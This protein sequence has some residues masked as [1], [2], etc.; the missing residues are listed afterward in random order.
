MATQKNQA[1]L[2]SDADTLAVSFEYVAY[3]GQLYAPVDYETGDGD[4]VP[5]IERKCWVPLST[6]DVR[7]KAR[8]QFNTMFKDENQLRGFT[9]MVAQSSIEVDSAPPWLLVKTSQGLRVMK[10]DGQ[11]HEPDGSF[12]P[13]MLMP[14]LNENADDKAE[15]MSVITG[16]LGGEEEEALSLLRHLA[17]T[18]APHWSAGKYVL[19]IG[20]GSNGKSV[21]MTMLLDLFGVHN[22][23]GV[24]RQV[25]S[26]GS[27]GVFDLNGKL[28]NLVF[29]GPAEFVKDS[30]KEKSV[31]TG[32][33]IKIRRL[34]SSEMSTIKTNALFV[35]GL[36]QEPRSRDKSSAL[37][38]RLVRFWFPN[39]Y[40]DDDAFFQRMRSEQMLGALLSLLMDNYVLPENKQIMLAQTVTSRQLQIEHMEANSLALQ[41]VVYLE[42][43]EPLGAEATLID[44]SID[45]LVQR[46]Q[47]WRVRCNDLAVW[48]KAALINMFNPVVQTERRSTRMPGKSYPVKVRH[49]TGLKQD[50]IDLLKATKEE[51]EDDVTAVVED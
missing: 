44:M 6:R 4:V 21:L 19:L 39:K 41:F 1:E 48:D 46:F 3:N 25:I 10:E 32:E 45:D 2:T 35:E 33:Q 12:V 7:L 37:Q 47:S 16:W 24:E 14:E 27:P 26:E 29:D 17:T 23:S 30:G 42:E 13:N 51:E 38:R 8:T 22:C 15:L 43:T 20:D 5:P 9:F 34:Y 28:L 31:I 50:A 40:L 49:I 18:L 36:N 11:L